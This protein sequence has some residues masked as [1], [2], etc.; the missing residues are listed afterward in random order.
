MHAPPS[1]PLSAPS[2]PPPLFPRVPRSRS[3]FLPVTRTFSP[4]TLSCSQA[5]SFSRWNIF[6]C[7]FTTTVSPL[8]K[9]FEFIATL[10]KHATDVFTREYRCGLFCFLLKWTRK[11]RGLRGEKAR[12]SQKKEIIHLLHFLLNFFNYNFFNKMLLIVL[13]HT[14]VTDGLRGGREPR[15]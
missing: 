2:P 15:L 7:N 9:T 12:E 3:G 11:R 6:K 8:F 4:T 1:S 5:Q 10:F 13:G 14:Y